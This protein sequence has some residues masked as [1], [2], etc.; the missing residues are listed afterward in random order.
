MN[1]YHGPSVLGLVRGRGRERLS[2]EAITP[3]LSDD[4]PCRGEFLL[5]EQSAERAVAVRVTEARAGG[6]FGPGSE[7]GATYLAE[8]LKAG[9]EGVSEDVKAMLHRLHLELHVLGV[10]VA[11]RGGLRFEAGHRDL[12]PFGYRLRRPSVEALRF[13]ASAGLQ[14]G[15]GVIRFG[16]FAL[17]HDVRDDL[18]VLF[19]ID[20]LRSRRSFVFARAGYGKSNLVKILIERLYEKPPESGLLILDPEGEYAFEQQAERG[21]RVPGLADHRELRARLKVFTA[22]QDP[23]LRERYADVIQPTLKLDFG[24]CEPGEVLAAFVHKEKLEQVWTNWLRSLA[25]RGRSG[26]VTVDDRWRELVRTLDE[27]QYS[28]SDEELASLLFR[29]RYQPARDKEKA[30][31]VS[32][33]AIRNNLIPLLRRVHDPESTLLQDA[34]AWL[35]RGNI[36]VLDLSLASHADA[37]ALANLLMFR[38]FTDRVRSL[39]AGQRKKDVIAVFEEAQTLLSR[40][41][42]ETSVFVRWVKEGRKYGLGAL[43]ITQQPGSIATEIVSQGDNF[44]V[45]HL[46]GEEDLE[47]LQ[48][49]N[50]H[51]T[52]D[53]V[54]CIRGEPVRGNCYFWSAPD[55]PYVVPC[56][57]A[58]FDE[59]ARGP[60]K[61]PKT[62]GAVAARQTAGDAVQAA[63]LRV[64]ALDPKVFLLTVAA[65]EGKAAGD[66]IAVSPIYLRRA[67]EAVLVEE[68][69]AASV[70]G[71]LR[72]P[73]GRLELLAHPVE[74]EGEYGG[75]L[76]PWLLLHRPRLAALAH[77]A[78]MSLKA[79]VGR[80]LLLRA[81][82]EGGA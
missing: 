8:L 65:L 40:R 33:Q 41:E 14:E 56:R 39:T 68:G 21:H 73:L 77:E 31:N 38:L 4:P 66:V 55:Q 35:D 76:R 48:R 58:N 67:L 79:T 11:E 30:G 22:R 16:S 2:I 71:N 81:R 45:M 57:V 53:L 27:K 80:G 78:G 7:S 44:F 34:Q 54:D 25:R 10:V 17:G 42:E 20:R 29:G 61:L 3:G 47:L 50:A 82:A 19:S 26:E 60:G 1:L 49:V 28:V 9:S 70:P 18:P 74:V 24:A 51:F 46:L 15:E 64:L 59:L 23:K 63:L 62:A 13:L 72:V 12:D 36:V 32:L 43:M 5:L 69:G 75:E 6:P 37:R 52:E